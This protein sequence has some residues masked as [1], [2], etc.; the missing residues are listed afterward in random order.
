MKA[1]NASL[2]AIYQRLTGGQGDAY[3]AFT[4]DALLLFSEGVHFHV[5]SALHVNA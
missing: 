5:R 4:E 2:G 3:L 1:V